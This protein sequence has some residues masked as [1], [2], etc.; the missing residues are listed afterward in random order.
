MGYIVKIIDNKGETTT[1]TVDNLGDA[2]ELYNEFCTK[3]AYI[4]EIINERNG[5]T[6]CEFDNG[7]EY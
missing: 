2:L 7:L 1:K 3:L 5:L 6:V 4:G